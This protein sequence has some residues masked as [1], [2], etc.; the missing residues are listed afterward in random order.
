MNEWDAWVK[1]TPARA[2]RLALRVSLGASYDL[3][4]QF[5]GFSGADLD[6]I[7]KAVQ[8]DVV[9]QG[10][11]QV[12][13]VRPRG[14][15]PSP[16]ARRGMFKIWLRPPMTM[17]FDLTRDPSYKP[18]TF[19]SRFMW[20]ISPEWLNTYGVLYQGDNPV[21]AYEVPIALGDIPEGR[22]AAL[23]VAIDHYLETG[24]PLR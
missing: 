11:G 21:E 10:A 9:Q 6:R 22:F 5:S 19:G 20:A 8:A 12:V 3:P 17:I 4:K 14:R 18:S 2:E 15:G 23:R 1:R 24:R 7:G 16:N 13:W